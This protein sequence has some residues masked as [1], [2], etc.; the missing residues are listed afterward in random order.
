MALCTRI[1]PLEGGYVTG[2][3]SGGLHTKGCVISLVVRMLVLVA[4]TVSILAVVAIQL[5]QKYGTMWAVAPLIII[6]AVGIAA[7]YLYWRPRYRVR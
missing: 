6:G 2:N 5:V 7:S 1:P 4:V 3:L